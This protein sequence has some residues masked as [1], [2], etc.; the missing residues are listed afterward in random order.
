MKISVRLRFLLLTIIAYCPYISIF[1]AIDEDTPKKTDIIVFS[2]NRP[3]Q[4]FAYLESAT[5]LIRGF[6]KI[7]VLYRADDSEYEASYRQVQQVFNN[8]IF[9][10]QNNKKSYKNFKT[11]VCNIIERQSKQDYIVFAVD[12]IIVCENIDLHDC[13]RHLKNNADAVGFYLRLGE[14]ISESYSLSIKNIL[15][16]VFQ[17]IR[18]NI[19]KWQFRGS[20]DEWNYPHSLDMTVYKKSYVIGPLKYLK[21]QAPN[22]LEGRWSVLA[23]TEPYGLCYTHSKI[24]N[25]PLNLV[26]SEWGSK[27]MSMLSAETLLILFQAGL[28]INTEKLVSIKNKS[29]HIDYLPSFIPR[30]TEN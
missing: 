15:L 29:P 7:I 12:D 28:K 26:Q 9:V 4:L 8:V 14:N 17:K 5:T 6:D 3:L 20:A 22:S 27:H 24:V 11:N 19:L 2:Y 21:Y 16:P 30:I 18:P 10:K 13:I 25:I 23:P 1:A